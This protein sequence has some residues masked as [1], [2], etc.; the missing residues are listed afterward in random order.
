[1]TPLVVIIELHDFLM[2]VMS[3]ADGCENVTLFTTALSGRYFADLMGLL[4]SV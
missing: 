4:Q 3:L 2:A 1:M